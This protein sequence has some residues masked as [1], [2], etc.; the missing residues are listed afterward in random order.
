MML[1][2]IRRRGPYR[3]G[4][5]SSTWA[6]VSAASPQTRHLP[7]GQSV[8]LHCIH[9]SVGLRPMRCRYC[10]DRPQWPDLSWWMSTAVSLESTP[11][12]AG[13]RSAMM[14]RYHPWGQAACQL[15]L[16]DR[17]TARVRVRTSTGV[18]CWSSPAASLAR[19]SASSLPGRPQWAGTHCRW[20][21]LP[22][23]SRRRSWVHSRAPI[24]EV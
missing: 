14:A 22:V 17:A 3:Q 11:T 12:G 5:L 6:G 18:S 2:S 4:H 15:F 16:A 8:S 21:V 1:P 19:A 10:S 20:T 24:A 13:A 7:A 23:A 9:R